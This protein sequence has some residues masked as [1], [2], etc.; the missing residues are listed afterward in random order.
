M[1]R[2]WVNILP[3]FIVRWLAQR[4]GERFTYHYGVHERVFVQST[5]DCF[6]KIDAARTGESDHG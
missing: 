3:L 2:A 1:M 4:Y 5:R 6:F